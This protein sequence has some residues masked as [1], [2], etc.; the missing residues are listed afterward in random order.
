MHIIR[1]VALKLVASHAHFTVATAIFINKRAICR[2]MSLWDSQ[3][4]QTA[5]EQI[6]SLKWIYHLD[7]IAHGV[8]LI[9]WRN[10]QFS[11]GVEIRCRQ[12]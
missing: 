7:S 6:C 8:R 9:N 2:G 12:L 1:K 4:R 10:P 5:S 3:A 11:G